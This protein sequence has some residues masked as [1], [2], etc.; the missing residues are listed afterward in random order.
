MVKFKRIK[1]LKVEV[2]SSLIEFV[3]YNKSKS[4]MQ[5]RF[6]RGKT[7]KRKKTFEAISPQDFWTIINS[8]SIGRAILKL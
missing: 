7:S 5:V 8:E 4:Q 6:K 3:E 1:Q 2:E